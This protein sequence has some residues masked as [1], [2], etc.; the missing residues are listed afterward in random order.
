MYQSGFIPLNESCTEEMVEG[1]STSRCLYMLNMTR[2]WISLVSRLRCM[3]R[4]VWGR[5]CSL[6]MKLGSGTHS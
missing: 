6:G 4:Y 3:G 2:D 5:G 1:L